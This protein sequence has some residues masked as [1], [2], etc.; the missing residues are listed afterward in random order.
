M[1]FSKSSV[2]INGIEYTKDVVR[3]MIAEDDA[4][5][6]RA[7]L[8]IY[9][10]QTE[11]EK[12]AEQTEEHN[13]VGFNGTDAEIGSSF[14]KWIQ[15]RGKLTEPQRKVA[16][17]FMPKYAGQIFRIMQAKAESEPGSEKTHS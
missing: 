16:R 15:R 17:K 8:V 9:E 11:S 4:W 5:L 3:H 14:A 10:Y 1:T 12:Q 6:E 13:G 2:M 7:V